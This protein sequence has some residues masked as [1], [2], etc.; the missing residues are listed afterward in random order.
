VANAVGRVAAIAQQLATW[1][2][3]DTVALRGPDLSQ[4]LTTIV[5]AGSAQAP[6]YAAAWT[7]FAAGIPGNMTLEEVLSFLA[8][9]DEAEQRQILDAV[10]VRLGTAQ[11]AAT[12]QQQ[13]VRVLTMH[14]AKGLSG[15]VVFIP[16][17]EQG[18]MPSFRG[19]HAAGLLNEQRRLFYVSLTRARAACIV[20]HAALH[21]G[22]PAFLI[23]QK[24]QVSLPRSQFLGEMGSVSVNRAQGL[25]A[26]EAQGILADINNL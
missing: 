8:A 9:D 5:F 20:S 10:L 18:I 4:L 13:R 17:A 23:Q 25:T 6:A 2:L 19:I 14:G 16:G 24:P 1:T 11:P 21:T 22:P 7:A 26:A 3:Q 12:G 15:K